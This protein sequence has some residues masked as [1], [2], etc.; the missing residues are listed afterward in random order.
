[1]AAM[2]Q[3]PATMLGLDA[4][5]VDA[6]LALLVRIVRLAQ[7]LPQQY[8]LGRDRGVG[9]E[10]ED[11]VPVAPLLM[12]QRLHGALNVDLDRRQLV[13]CVVHRASAAAVS[14]ERSAPSIVAGSPVSVQS[15][16]R[17]R[18]AQRVRHGGRRASCAGVAAKVARFSL[19]MRPGGIG[20]ERLWTAATSRQ[21]NAVSSGVSISSRRS[22]ALTVTD[23]RS[24]KAKTHS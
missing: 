12:H 5:K 19:T 6:D 10:L 14:P 23:S 16:A 9:L 24:A 8:V 11:P 2:E 1:R 3:R 15:P 17:N 13:Q 7:I 22:A 20:P 21:S 18:F 4:A